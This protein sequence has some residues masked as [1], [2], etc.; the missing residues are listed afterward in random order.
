MQH[1]L[2]I[3]FSIQNVSVSTATL[4]SPVKVWFG[5]AGESSRWATGR[6]PLQSCR[7]RRGGAPA[8]LSMMG[9]GAPAD[10]CGKQV[11]QRQHSLSVLGATSTSKSRDCCFS[12]SFVALRPSSSSRR[13][14]ASETWTAIFAPGRRPTRVSLRRR[15]VFPSHRRP[16]S[17]RTMVVGM[18]GK[19]PTKLHAGGLMLCWQRMTSCA[20]S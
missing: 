5:R 2:P 10:D 1:A 3:R 4:P 15:V 8:L 19:P 11:A 18:S 7:G 20:W 14:I 17:C 13:P 6:T 12:F 9:R 16:D